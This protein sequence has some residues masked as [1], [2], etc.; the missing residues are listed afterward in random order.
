MG[1][2][3]LYETTLGLEI[4]CHSVGLVL[5]AA[6]HEDRQAV[7]L[8]LDGIHST[9]GTYNIAVERH[10]DFLRLEVH[11]LVLHI[12]SAIEESALGVSVIDEGVLGNVIHWCLDGALLS[13]IE[14]VGLDGVIDSLIVGED[15]LVKGVEGDS[16]G[17]GLTPSPYLRDRRVISSRPN[18]CYGKKE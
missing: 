18:D 10:I 5:V 12:G 17:I 16:V 2:G 14:G 9:R 7:A 15:G 1:V 6:H 11:I 8:L 4:E 13:A 3:I